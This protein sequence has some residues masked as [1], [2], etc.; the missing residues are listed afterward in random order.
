[1]TPSTPDCPS[2]AGWYACAVVDAEVFQADRAVLPF[3]D[4]PSH[5]RPAPGPAQDVF[6]QGVCLVVHLQLGGWGRMRGGCEVLSD[7]GV[8]QHL[9]R[10]QTLLVMLTIRPTHMW[11]RVD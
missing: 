11:G 4:R 7:F 10:H 2:R 3:G 6:A 9:S 8:A 5:R 1:M